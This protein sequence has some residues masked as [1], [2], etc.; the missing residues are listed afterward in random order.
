MSVFAD[1]N[2]HE[3][4]LRALEELSLSEPTPVQTAAI[5]PALAGRDLRVVA[6]TGTGK[7]A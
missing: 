3:R 6:R 7:T 5:P 2:L 1:L 4:L